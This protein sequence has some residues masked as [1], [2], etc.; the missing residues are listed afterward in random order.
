MFEAMIW[1][2]SSM[3]AEILRNQGVWTYG[4]INL[5]HIIGVSCIFGSVLILDLRLMNVWSS[6]SLAIIAKLTV[7]VATLGGALAIPSGLSMFAINTTQYHDN[8]FLYLKLPVLGAT[9][10]NVAVVTQ[11]GAWRRAT[12][13]EAQAPRD[14]A[15]LVFVGSTSLALWSTVIICGR[16]IGYW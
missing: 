7:P 9:L 3:F 2:E 10:I 14:R 6:I 1:L 11:L 8:P 16:M 15:V 13:D 5:I 12:V 4:I